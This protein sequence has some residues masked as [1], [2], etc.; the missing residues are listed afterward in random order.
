MYGKSPSYLPETSACPEAIMRNVADFLTSE[1]LIEHEAS[2]L[3]SVEA[4]ASRGINHCV[5]VGSRKSSS[6]SRLESPAESASTE[7]VQ[8]G[9]QS[10]AGAGAAEKTT[11]RK[12]LRDRDADADANHGPALSC[13]GGAQARTRSSRVVVGGSRL[14]ETARERPRPVVARGLARGPR[15]LALALA[16]AILV[17]REKIRG[18]AK[19]SGSE[20]APSPSLDSLSPL[21]SKFFEMAP[22]LPP[23]SASRSRRRRQCPAHDCPEL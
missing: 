6:S 3:Q 16:M 5:A 21:Y 8:A 10:E 14:P 17:G 23:A 2:N 12:R 9:R 19:R 1:R 7:Q 11:P 20:E 13:T 22:C 18:E 15:N 4:K